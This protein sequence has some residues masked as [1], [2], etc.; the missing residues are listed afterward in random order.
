MAGTES[1]LSQNGQCTASKSSIVQ[2]KK[3]FLLPQKDP[4]F[5]HKTLFTFNV[6]DFTKKKVEFKA[7]AAFKESFSDIRTK[8]TVK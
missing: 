3:A 7:S 8:L 2:S 6:P 5:Y 1:P 4:S